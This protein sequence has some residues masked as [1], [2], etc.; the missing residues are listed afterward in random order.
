[1]TGRALVRLAAIGLFS[2]LLSFLPSSAAAQYCDA[3]A[4]SRCYGMDDEEE[5]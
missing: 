2:F 3:E 1:M 5:C 4:A